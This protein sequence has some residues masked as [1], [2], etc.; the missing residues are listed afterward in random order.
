MRPER[1]DTAMIEAPTEIDRALQ[2]ALAIEPSPEFVARVRTRLAHE[3]VASGWR[4]AWLVVGAGAVAAA[5]AIAIVI[6]NPLEKTPASPAAE[7][8]RILPESPRS[9][10]LRAQQAARQD[11]AKT[12]EPGTHAMPTRA[13]QPPARQPSAMTQ[14]TEH[15]ASAG[16]PAGG[17]PEILI[18][19]REAA[20]LRWLITGTR[21]GSL[22]LSAALQTTVPAAL[23]P[24]PLSEIAIPLITIDPITPEAGDEGARQ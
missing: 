22:D 14:A 6:S 24:P 18:D 13:P 11:A 3:P 20:A 10:A 7:Q 5:I 17:E 8:R 16:R 2:T 15:L 12:R 21:D 19:P 23:D 9:G 4:P 1:D